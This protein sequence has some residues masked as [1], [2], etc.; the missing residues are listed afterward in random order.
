MCISESL[1]QPYLLYLRT[2]L[3]K[4]VLSL[5]QLVLVGGPEA[6]AVGGEDFIHQH[7]LISLLV[8][9]KLELGVCNDD[10]V[11]G[12]VVSCLISTTLAHHSH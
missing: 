11:F 2:H 3:V 5:A 4:A 12:S 7:D 8:E 6:R 9:S 1:S 10:A